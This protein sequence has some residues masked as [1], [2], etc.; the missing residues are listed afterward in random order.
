MTKGAGN[1]RPIYLFLKRLSG[2]EVQC[3]IWGAPGAGKED[4][5]AVENREDAEPEGSKQ[6]LW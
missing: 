5:P 3:W 6:K 4:S 1:D 2:R